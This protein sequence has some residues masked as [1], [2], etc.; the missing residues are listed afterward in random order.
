MSRTIE[1]LR[2]TISLYW[3]P[4]SAIGAEELAL[5]DAM[6]EKAAKHDEQRPEYTKF[7][8]CMNKQLTRYS[9]ERGESWKEMD[10]EEFLFR[11]QDQLA[12]LESNFESCGD[13]RSKDTIKRFERVLANIGNY[14]MFIH[15]N[16]THK[17]VARDE[18]EA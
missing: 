16:I 13:D 6:A 2:K 14:T 8:Q 11:I 3:S 7:V 10:S 12:E 5:F 15:D 1:D 18:V 9:K 17:R 4:N